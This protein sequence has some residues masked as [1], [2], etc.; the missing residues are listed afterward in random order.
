MKIE[1]AALTVVDGQHYGMLRDLR[2]AAG[3]WAVVSGIMEIRPSAC[4]HRD[5]YV[6][7]AY[8]DSRYWTGLEFG[9]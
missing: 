2:R 3:T 7:E 5:T 9:Q 6:A 8:F 4:I 1:I